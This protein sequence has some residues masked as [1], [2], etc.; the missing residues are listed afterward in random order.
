MRIKRYEGS[1]IQEVLQ[2]IKS[3]LGRDAV[4]LHSQRLRKGGFL[5]LGA[6]LRYEVLAATDLNTVASP[7]TPS[8]SVPPPQ[9]NDL[10][11]EEIKRLKQ[12]IQSLRASLGLMAQGRNTE[13]L[14]ALTSVG[15]DPEV[16]AKLLEDGHPQTREELVQKVA[17]AFSFAG[18]LLNGNSRQVVALIGPTGVGKTTTIAKMAAVAS[19]DQKA[20]VALV[21]SDTYRIGAVD[22]LRTYCQILRL[23]LDVALSP[24]EMQAAVAAHQDKDL[25][26]ID[27]VG[28]G[29]RHSLQLSELGAMLRAANPT[30]IHLVLSASSDRYVM[31][32][33]V[34]K[35]GALGA[36][37]LI[38]TKLDEAVR[39]GELVNVASAT[40]MP[41]SYFTD[42]QKVP[43]DLHLADPILLAERIVG[44]YHA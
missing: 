26:L 33:V 18:P 2:R 9:D 24:D 38:F 28:R 1:D 3:E 13:P 17:S 37:R 6:K 27:T 34:E 41:V 29:Q 21:T 11:M 16:A 7:P 32:E 35:F 12:E 40:K 14:N 19:L 20:K 36:D 39:P 5:G 10:A 31:M 23:P 42:G 22:Q 15:V 44:D 43:E 30:Q 8:P 4:I 25:I